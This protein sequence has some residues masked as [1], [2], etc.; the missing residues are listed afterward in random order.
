MIKK[1]FIAQNF[2]YV[3]VPYTNHHFEAIFHCSAV[4]DFTLAKLYTT[5]NQNY[6]IDDLGSI[7]L[8]SNICLSTICL[9]IW[10][11]LESG[12][13]SGITSVH[14]NSRYY[15]IYLSPLFSVTFC[16]YSHPTTEFL[17]TI[18]DAD[19]NFS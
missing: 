15:L 18:D 10:R 3:R 13:Y 11:Y 1:Y 6:L 12:E 16:Y 14:L 9:H 8:Q 7:I 5:N 4:A 2:Y 19:E 17:N